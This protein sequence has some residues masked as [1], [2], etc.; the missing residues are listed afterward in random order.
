VLAACVLIAVPPGYRVPAA[1]L[2]AATPAD[3]VSGERAHAVL[4]RLL[5]GKPRPTGSAGDAAFVARLET[6]LRAVGLEPERQ[7]VFETSPCGTCGRVVNVL[8]R[9]PGTRDG[10]AILLSAH[11]DSMPASP[12]ASDDGTGMVALLEVARALKAAPAEAPVILLF[13]DGEEPG[14]LGMRAFLEQHRWRG[15][16]R[17][18]INADG[19]GS[20]GP[21]LMH[22]TGIENTGLIR[23]LAREL[24]APAASSVFQTVYELLPATDSDLTPWVEEGRRALNF[25]FLGDPLHYHSTSDRLEHVSAGTLQA[26]ADALLAAVR[27]AAADPGCTRTSGDAVYFDVLGRLLVWWPESWS[28]MFAVATILIALL[29]LRGDRNGALRGAALAFAA[30]CGAT[31]AGA[32]L[33]A[34]WGASGAL[35]S[36]WIAVPG[37]ALAAQRLAALVSVGLL[38]L[39]VGATAAPGVRTGVWAAWSLAGAVMALVAPGGAYLWVLPALATLPLA[40]RAQHPL[41]QAAPFAVAAV[42]WLPLLDRMYSA[43]G[44]AIPG[45]HAALHAM[46]VGALLPALVTLPLPARR[47]VVGAS[48]VACLA[49]T[50]RATLQPPFDDAHPQPVLVL[51]HRDAAVNQSRWLASALFGPPAVR[52]PAG[53]AWSRIATPPFPFAGSL[54]R[55]FKAPAEPGAEPAPLLTVLEDRRAGAAHTL[56]LRLASR[57]GAQHAGLLLPPSAQVSEIVVEAVKLPPPPPDAL[58][59]MDGWR[60]VY[61]PAL[62]AEGIAIELT[63]TAPEPA[64]IMLFDYTEGL[65]APLPERPSSACSFL[66]EDG[67]LVTDRVKL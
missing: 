35:P 30:L 34:A 59:D 54:S 43:L 48:I 57:R 53:T 63:R 13:T 42:V 39:T 6:E 18:A 17:L 52:L 49:F 51:R 60:L 27:G 26:L 9:I 31:A 47:V 61:C 5:D 32:A 11:H 37:P 38:S 7:E 40:C 29:H 36:L 12:G 14:L 22:Q 15:D 20:G 41:L 62:P 16:V 55:M 67:V 25:A 4:E 66:Y 21:V 3:Q 45:G 56:R 33:Q 24:P 19:R 10:G 1:R 44:F 65:P 58:A 8:A 50:A 64:E 46:P 23:M 28:P 2:A